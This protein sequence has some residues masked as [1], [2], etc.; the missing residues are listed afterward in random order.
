MVLVA[1]IASEINDLYDRSEDI[2]DITVVLRHNG[3]TSVGKIDGD[4][5]RTT[6]YDGVLS[7]WHRIHYK[8]IGVITDTE[9]KT[10]GLQLLA[11][12][13]GDI[14]AERFISLI[15]R[16]PFDYTKWR[17]GLDE[18]LSLAEI[19]HRAIAARARHAAQGA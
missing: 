15:Q 11:Q 12:H 9:L 19:S 7:M 18:E 2:F 14:E 4:R 16:E 6:T 3:P 10:K 5:L 13:L 1:T 17:Q 8:E